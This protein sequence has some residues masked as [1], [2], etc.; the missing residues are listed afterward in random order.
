MFGRALLFLLPAL[1]LV[2]IWGAFFRGE[3]IVLDDCTVIRAGDGKLTVRA[4][5]GGAQTAAVASDAK[6][7]LNGKGCRLKDLK[8]EFK[9]KI[10]VVQDGDTAT[11]TCIEAKRK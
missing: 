1:V 11:I 6:I 3:K 10:T 7:T 9:V 4:P 8:K 2:A 5:K